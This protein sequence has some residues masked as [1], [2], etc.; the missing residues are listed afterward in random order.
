MGR[1]GPGK[2]PVATHKAQGTFR[3]DRHSDDVD[4]QLESKV[5]PPP[6]HF[7]GEQREL[8]QKLGEKLASKGLLTELDAIA[9]ELLVGSFVGMR[10]TASELDGEDL[11]Y[12]TDSGAPIVNPRVGVI[13]KH[14]ALLKWALR[15]FGCTPSARTG[16]KV[17]KARQPIAD[18]MAQLLGG[19]KK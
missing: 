14:T 12:L 5:P 16:I 8:W 10:K 17:E 4:S 1:R 18:P 13:A 19:I 11:V 9:F 3:A 6:E 2:K 7:D 15:E